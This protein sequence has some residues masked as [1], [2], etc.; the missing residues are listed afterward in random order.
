MNLV[1]R[2]FGIKDYPENSQPTLMELYK[3]NLSIAWPATVEGALMAII[4]SVDT[5]MVGNVGTV[6]ISAVSLVDSINNLV[7]QVF[8]A[9]ATGATIVCSQYLGKR[10]EK[11]SNRAARQVIL[12][13]LSIS[14]LLM[15]IFLII[16][17]ELQVQNIRQ[18]IR[19][20]FYRL[21]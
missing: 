12:A 9:L 18:N 1:R 5:M 10:D 2:C 15:I 4:G 6:A 14:V 8:S 16:S 13:V 3:E 11:G 21:R 7:I 20:P 19:L 17:Q